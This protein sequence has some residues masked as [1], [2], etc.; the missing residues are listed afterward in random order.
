M[1]GWDDEFGGLR[2]VGSG[3][4]EQGQTGGDHRSDIVFYL[5]VLFIYKYNYFIH[6]LIRIFLT[7]KLSYR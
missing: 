3:C 2:L 7:D 6:I 5:V 4:G 1:I